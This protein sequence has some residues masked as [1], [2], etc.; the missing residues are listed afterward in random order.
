MSESVWFAG[1]LRELRE[2]TGLT[3]RQLAEKAGMALGGLNKLEQGVNRPSWESV[4]LLSKALGVSVT[5][6]LTPPARREPAGRG[7][8]V[9]SEKP[10]RPRKG[11]G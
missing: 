3:Q 5:A 11:A 8:P 1:R 10:K 9:K 2:E 6:F 7:R 4:L